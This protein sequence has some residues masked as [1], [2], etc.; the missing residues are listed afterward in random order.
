MR[1]GDDECWARLGTAGHGVLATVHPRRGADLVP[2]VFALAAGVGAAAG[3]GRPDLVVPVDVV[4]AK[5]STRLQ[6]LE[7][8]ARDDRCALLVDHYEDDWTRLWWVR[9]HARGRLE[10]AS[11]EIMEP[12]VTRFAQYSGEGTVVE[13]IR[14][15]VTEVV[16]WS[17]SE[18]AA[19]EAAAPEAPAQT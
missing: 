19:S 9:V 16:G 12:L 7:N 13:V 5:S 3:G 17:A 6:R 4:K 18:A 10:P 8:L 14:L 1:L 2:V 11:P 15:T